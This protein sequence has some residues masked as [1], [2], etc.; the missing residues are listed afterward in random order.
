MMKSFL[1]IIADHLA[2]AF[3]TTAI[4]Y[5]THIA[6]ETRPRTHRAGLGTGVERTLGQEIRIIALGSHWHQIRFRMPRAVPRGDDCVF[7]L[8]ENISRLI[9]QQCAKQ[10]IAVLPCLFEQCQWQP[11]SISGYRHPSLSPVFHDQ[12]QRLS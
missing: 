12:V 8:Q 10:M 4:N 3:L 2:E 9:D 11:A 7:S 6:P 1:D 5:P